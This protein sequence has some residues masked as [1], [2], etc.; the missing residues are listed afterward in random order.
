[1]YFVWQH[2]YLTIENIYSTRQMVNAI[3][4]MV[5]FL[6]LFALSCEPVLQLCQCWSNNKVVLHWT[7][8]AC[9]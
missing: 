8:N 4:N 9:N 5:I 2:L 7:K 3:G 6:T 1:M